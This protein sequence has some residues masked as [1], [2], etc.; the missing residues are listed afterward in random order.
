MLSKAADAE[1]RLASRRKRPDAPRKTRRGVVSWAQAHYPVR[2]VRG[3]PHAWKPLRYLADLMRVATAPDGPRSIVLWKG[4]QLGFTQMLGALYCWALLERDD[5]VMLVLPTDAEAT[6]YHR[7][8]VAPLYKRVPLLT[9]LRDATED[10]NAVKGRHKVFDTGASALVQGG[11]VADRYRSEAVEWQMLDEVDAYPSD[12]DEG[13]AVT[14]SQRAVQNTGGVVIAGSTPTSA[15]GASQIVAAW[16]AADLTCVFVVRCPECGE[17]DQPTWER[18]VIAAN[19]SVVERGASARL[20][21]GRCGAEWTHDQLPGAIRRGRWQEGA[22]A[23]RELFPRPVYDG[24]HVVSESHGPGNP[25]TT[26]LRAADGAAVPW[27][28]NVGFAVDGLV[29]TWAD[30]SSYVRRALRAEGDPRKE[31]AFSEQVLARPFKADHGE[32]D[33]TNLRQRAIPLSALPDGHRLAVCSVDV[34]DGWLSMHVLIFGPRRNAVIVERREFNGDIDCVGGSAWVALREWLRSEPTWEG[35]RIRLLVCDTGFQSGWTMRNLRW[36][37]RRH[38][39][40]AVKGRAG[41]DEPDWRRSKTV[42]DGVARRLYI[43]GVDPLKSSVTRRLRK[44]EI[45]IADDLP[46]EV[47]A[48]LAGERLDDVVVK[49]RKERRWV[50]HHA[51]V[52][53]LDCCVYATAAVEIAQIADIASLPLA[54]PRRRRSKVADRLAASGHRVVKR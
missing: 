21:C 46:E 23:D 6:K 3:Q 28:P 48:E 30:W 44:G 14:L 40:Y 24:V 41:W 2:V 50:Q 37:G 42:V 53:A 17:Y 39:V 36:L 52:E 7:S 8:Y 31:R 38:P 12:L 29:S 11:G 9:Q 47:E 20:A 25:K 54:V 10:R 13:D 4:A 32:I 35:R 16:Q 1:R 22:L 27:P 34:Q 43:V 51:R 33:A 19:G 18:M 26:R 45:K 5:R 15:R 49:G